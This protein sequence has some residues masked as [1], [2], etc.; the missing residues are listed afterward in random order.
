M[1]TQKVFL[2]KIDSDESEEI[3]KTARRNHKNLWRGVS[4]VEGDTRD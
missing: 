1:F 2:G 3:I 4:A